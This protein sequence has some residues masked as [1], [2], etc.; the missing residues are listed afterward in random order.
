[1]SALRRVPPWVAAALTLTARG[2]AMEQRA[3]AGS[4]VAGPVGAAVGAGAGA[5]ADKVSK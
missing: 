1:M 3:S 5:V 4:V 2:H